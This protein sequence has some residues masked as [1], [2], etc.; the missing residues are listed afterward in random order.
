MKYS[1]DLE[2][3]YFFYQSVVRGLYGDGWFYFFVQ[4]LP[5]LIGLHFIFKAYGYIR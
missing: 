1:I 5:Y 3:Y 4:D 2:D